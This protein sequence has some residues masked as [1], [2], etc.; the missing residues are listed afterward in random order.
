MMATVVKQ[1]GPED[2]GQPM[3]FDEFLSGDYR[4]GYH[5]EL[6]DGKLYVTPLP[7]PQECGV[8][9]WILRK[10]E[11][12]TEV[13]PEVANFAANKT[14]VFVPH[15]EDTTAPEPDVAVFRKFP[16]ERLLTDLSWDE[17]SPIL[18]V[19]VLTSDD[20]RKDTVRNVELYLQVPS[21][22]EYWIIDARADAARPTMRVYRKYRGR[23]RTPLDLQPGDTYTTRLLPG[24]E[25]VIDPTR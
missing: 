25:L 14:R 23:W 22:K 21:I 1:L 17:V 24:F 3:S 2:H 4:E 20:P 7:S 16:L 15:R 5:Y 12:Y 10:L 6:I 19:E 11:N 18:V 8:E 9:K 13:Y